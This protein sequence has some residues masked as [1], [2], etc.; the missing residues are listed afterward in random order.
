M[1]YLVN[2]HFFHQLC[3]IVFANHRL[4]LWGLTITLAT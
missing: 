3:T 4:L 2:P 1:V